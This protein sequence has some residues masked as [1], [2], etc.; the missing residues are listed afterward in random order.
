VSEKSVDARER[1][2]ERKKE[3]N[4]SL[5]TFS[6]RNEVSSTY[7]SPLAETAAALTAE[8]RAEARDREGE[9]LV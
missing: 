9:R 1:K 4:S 6:M 5:F 7:S 8:R 2:E 3:I